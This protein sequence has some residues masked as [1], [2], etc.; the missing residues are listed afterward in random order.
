[1]GLWTAKVGSA[2]AGDLAGA[3]VRPGPSVRSGYGIPR[4]LRRG[5]SVRNAVG[6]P[7]ALCRRQLV[8][9]ELLREFDA[10][11]TVGRGPRIGGGDPQPSGI[12]P[13]SLWRFPQQ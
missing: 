13:A 5:D 2:Y 12:P 7:M 8:A 3:S 11:G 1:M 9:N 4:P 10:G 6:G